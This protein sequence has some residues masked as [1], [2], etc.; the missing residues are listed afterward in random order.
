MKS[1][2]PPLSRLA[3]ALGILA[4]AAPLIA[5]VASPALTIVF[6]L[7]GIAALIALWQEGRLSAI[8]R[9]KAAPPLVLLLIWA[10]LSA[11]WAI[12]AHAA[13]TLIASLIALFLFALA[14]QAAAGLLDE[15]QR[16]RFGRLLLIGFLI[17]TALLALDVVSGDLVNR[18]IKLALTG[19][20]RIGGGVVDRPVDL[21]VLSGFAVAIV[22]ARAGHR[23]AAIAILFPAPIINAFT[24]SDSSRLAGLAGLLV[25]ALAW[26]LGP[27]LVR[28]GGVIAAILA[29]VMPLLPLGPLAPE[30]WSAALS[31]VKYSA[32]HRLYIWRFAADHI[33]EHP[34]IGWGMNSSRDMPGGKTILPTGGQ[35]MSLH[36]H[37][38]LLQVW[39][40]LG[41]PGALLAAWLLCLLFFA[42]ARIED[43]FARAAI[44]GMLTASLVI[45]CLSFGI[46]QNWWVSVLSLTAAYAAI[47]AP[48]PE[49]APGRARNRG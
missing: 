14:L 7:A 28:A 10:A 3:L 17:G 45:A 23:L 42:T 46:W 6:S 12:S 39:L 22:L 8:A 9:V 15:A 40:E 36:P 2:S 35:A 43:R 34:L 47:L 20:E 4:I 44:A 31:H 30:R 29:L 25:V 19:R 13:L 32:L 5:L 24:N 18:L 33:R 27:K 26:W 16:R 21:A 1:P 38:G 48:G 41:L 37:N 49:A 11:F